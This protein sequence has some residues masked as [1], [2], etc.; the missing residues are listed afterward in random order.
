MVY[1][2]TVNNMNNPKSENILS[3]SKL[4]VNLNNHRI[5]EDIDFEVSRDSTLAIIGPNGAGKTVLFKALLGFLPYKGKVTWAENARIG[6]VPQ[7]LFIEKDLP[8]TVSEFLSFKKTSK[9][10]LMEI[11]ESVGLGES[12]VRD[13]H[14]GKRLLD[15]RMGALSGGELQRVLIIFALLGEPNVLLFDEPTAGVDVTGEETIYALIDKLKK[16]K[17]LTIIFISHEL[18]VVYKYADNVLCLNKVGV[19]FGPPKKAIDKDSLHAMY[20]EDVHVHIHD[21]DHHHE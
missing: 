14:R 21:H 5:L 17:D 10:K 1:V 3:V 16:E 19:C 20:G 11:F 12:S 13:P 4:G 15:T 8:L 7:K 2:P 6:Y 18:N 9:S